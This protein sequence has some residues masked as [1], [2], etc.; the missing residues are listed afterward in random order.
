MFNLSF[1]NSFSLDKSKTSSLGGRVNK[2]MYIE[3]FELCSIWDCYNFLSIIQTFP[4]LLY[5]C[6]VCSFVMERMTGRR[7]CL[8]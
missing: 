8:N 6:F 5:G 1:A 2:S 3:V 7:I 4:A